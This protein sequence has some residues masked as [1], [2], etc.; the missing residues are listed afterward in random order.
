MAVCLTLMLGRLGG[1][2]GVNMV[3][4]LIEDHCQLTFG[5]A[6]AIMLGIIIYCSI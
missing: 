4:L 5:L 1:V 3:A 6:G 2:F